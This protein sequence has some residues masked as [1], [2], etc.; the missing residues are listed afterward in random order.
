MTSKSR[1]LLLLSASLPFAACGGGGG[2]AAPLAPTT[3]FSAPQF[4]PTGGANSRALTIADFDHDGIADVLVANETFASASLLKGRADGSLAAGVLVPAPSLV[5]TVA[6]ADV[7]GDRRIDLVA[8]SG[9]SSEASVSLGL[10]SGGFGAASPFALP[11]AARKVA[12]AD[13]TGDGRADLL[14]ASAQTAEIAL[15]A[16][17]GMG[18]FGSAQIVSLAF[19][20][21]EFA[22]VDTNGDRRLDLVCTG[23]GASR[24][25]TLRNDGVGGFLPAISTTAPALAGRFVVGDL[26]GDLL[27]DL[28]ALDASATAVRVFRGTGAGAFAS[29]SERSVAATAVQSLALGDLDADGKTD[30]VVVAGGQLLASHG[31]GAGVFGDMVA[32]HTDGLGAGWVAVGDLVGDGTADVLY[33]SGSDRIGVLRNTRPAPVGLVAYGTGTPDCAGRIGMWANGAPRIGNAQYGYLTTNAPANAVG[34]LLQGGPA[35][36]AGSNSLGIGALMHVGFGMVSTRLVFS[37][38]L[39]QCFMAEPIPAAPGLVGLPV[40]V[41]TLWQADLSRTCSVSPGGYATSA[42]LTSTLQP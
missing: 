6:V 38:P 12:L 19:A 7:D 29:A 2:G 13:W 22:I 21:A 20:V 16:G 5:S 39:G 25:D 42:G 28:V 26:D 11:W 10:G 32:L 23:T 17:N 31:N 33:V 30:L 40:Y 8:A 36:I 35:D 37:D 34:V 9:A 18:G 15:L 3:G 24:I 27:V 4:S 14:A 1:S 41:Q